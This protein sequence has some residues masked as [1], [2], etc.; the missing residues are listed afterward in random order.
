MSL[1]PRYSCAPQC[2]CFGNLCCASAVICTVCFRTYSASVPAP[3]D[4][5][6]HLYTFE[7]QHLRACNAF[8]HLCMSAPVQF[9]TLR[10]SHA[11]LPSKL[12]TCTPCHSQAESLPGLSSRQVRAACD[13][14]RN[15]PICNATNLEEITGGRPYSS[16]GAP[17]RAIFP[18]ILLMENRC[19]FPITVEQLEWVG[20]GFFALPQCSM[21]GK[22]QYVYCVSCP[23]PVYHG[24]QLS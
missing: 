14:E 12:S 19:L 21:P 24:C 6:M 9:C 20:E 2:V 1:I 16:C 15:P 23:L 17:Y 7:P 13:L 11:S 10:P 22:L 3:L 8:R 18:S 4:L 5:Y